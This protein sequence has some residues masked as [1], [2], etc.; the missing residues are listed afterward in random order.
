MGIIVAIAFFSAIV[1]IGALLQRRDAEPVNLALHDQPQR[2]PLP[3]ARDSHGV[4][5]MLGRAAVP[6]WG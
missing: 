3:G 1:A 6:S 4:T 5:G 2:T